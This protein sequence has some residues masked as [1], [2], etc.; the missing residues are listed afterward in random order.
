MGDGHANVFFSLVND[1]SLDFV[2]N[3]RAFLLN[4]SSSKF[5]VLNYD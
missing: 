1:V 5:E 4:C 2:A 3:S